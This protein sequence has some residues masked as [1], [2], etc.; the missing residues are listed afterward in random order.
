MIVYMICLYSYDTDTLRIPVHCIAQRPFACEHCGSA[1]KR[2]EHKTRHILLVHSTKAFRPT[3]GIKTAGPT[4]PLIL[5]T[6]SGIVN[7]QHQLVDVE[8]ST[9]NRQ[10]STEPKYAVDGSNSH[11]AN[12]A[13]PGIVEDSSK[14]FKC[15]CC[16]KTFRLNYHLKRHLKTHLKLFKCSKYAYTLMRKLNEGLCEY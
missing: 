8:A 11:L 2:D 4:E 1:F 5:N 15:H 13:D 14:C 12:V 6:D 9:A 16:E 7:S 10:S 3:T